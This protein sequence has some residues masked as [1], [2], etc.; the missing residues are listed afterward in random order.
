M[1][2]KVFYKNTS[3]DSIKLL[4]IVANGKEDIIRGL[5]TQITQQTQT[6]QDEQ[7]KIRVLTAQITQQTQTIQDAQE[8][9]RVLTAQ[10]TKQTQSIQQFKS[11]LQ[12]AQELNQTYHTLTRAL[13]EKIGRLEEEL[14]PN[15][16]QIE[17]KFKRLKYR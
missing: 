11:S 15:S 5:K 4:T 2:A 9:I 13:R 3:V 1:D 7:E 12:E 17:M 16:S 10:I 6:I 14:S 8:K